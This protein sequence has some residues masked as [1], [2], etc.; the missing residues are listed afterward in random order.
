MTG[1]LDM[2]FPYIHKNNIKFAHDKFKS[3]IFGF[4]IFD[5]L[6]STFLIN[7]IDKEIQIFFAN[8]NSTFNFSFLSN[9]QTDK[10]TDK[11]RF[12]N[13]DMTSLVDDD[14]TVEIGLFCPIA[15]FVV[16]SV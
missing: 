16:K 13:M 11:L 1:L 15:F 6:K 14:S 2:E 5:S 8:K 9:G 3:V 12:N 7:S 4:S 10:Q